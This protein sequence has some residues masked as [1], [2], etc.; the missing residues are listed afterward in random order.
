MLPIASMPEEGG[1][2]LDNRV[3]AL[4][5]QVQAGSTASAEGSDVSERLSALETKVE[6]A[7]SAEGA[8]TDP[9]ALDALRQDIAA[10]S[11]R[12]EAGAANGAGT[13]AAQVDLSGITSEI[14]G[15][16]SSLSSVE[17]EIK[18][19]DALSANLQ[20][21]Q[22]TVSGLSDQVD[23]VE[24]TAKAAQSA[25]STSDVSLKTLADSQSRSSESLAALSG[26]IQTLSGRVAANQTAIKEQLDTMSK[27]LAAVEATMGDAT[28]RELA[29]RALSI[30]ALKSAIDSG[31][32][33][34]AELAA[35]RAGLPADMDLSALTA[36]ADK[37]VSP[38]PTLIAEF[39]ATARAM[40]A[41]I[42]KPG[43]DGDVFDSLLSGARSLIAVRGPGDVSGEGPEAELR[44]MERAVGQ[45]DLETAL[46]AYDKLPDP[47]KD[48][49]AEWA[50]RARAR[51]AVDTLTRQTSD[52]VLRALGARDS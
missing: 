3:S 41:A 18:T 10:L 38:T 25:V 33:Y 34:Q 16:K 9:A 43:R 40:F 24:A 20:E 23:S 30:A 35:V 5:A 48:V 28:A 49:G 36:H 47:A 19:A 26:D 51:V 7:S 13:D 17:D 45:A 6:T 52:E 50:E 44:R 46:A 11:A 21:L 12:V 32:P 2:T 39:P 27:R 29:A 15:L 31:R 8:S 14:E 42:T 22:S 1:E 4:E 37:G